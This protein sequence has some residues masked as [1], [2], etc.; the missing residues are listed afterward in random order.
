[1][2]DLLRKMDEAR[3]RAWAIERGTFLS[4]HLAAYGRPCKNKNPRRS[5]PGRFEVP[6]CYVTLN[7]NAA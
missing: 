1:M 6:L 5:K 4:A 3:I 2:A 7:S